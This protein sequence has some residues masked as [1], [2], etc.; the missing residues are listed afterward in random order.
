MKE[1]RFSRRAFLAGS[2]AA[3]AAAAFGLAGCTPLESKSPESDSNSGDERKQSGYSFETA[4]EPIPESDISETI[5]ADVVI[6]GAGWSGIC[7]A[8]SCAQQGLSVN[9]VEQRDSFGTRGGD[10]NA[11]WSKAMEEQGIEREEIDQVLRR[12]LQRYDYNINQ[13]LWMRWWNNSEE[14]MNWLIDIAAKHGL[15]PAIGAGNEDPVGINT[16]YPGA[17]SFVLEDFDITGPDF[18]V[19]MEQ[20]GMKLLNPYLVEETEAAGGVFHYNNTAV[21]LVRDGEGAGRVSAIV[22]KTAD[23]TY[24][25]FVGTK[26]V[27]LAT[28]DYSGDEDMMQKYCAWAK[29]IRDNNM[30]EPGWTGNGDGHKMGMWAGAAW[31]QG[32]PSGAQI[33]QWS[34]EFLGTSKQAYTCHEGLMVNNQGKRFMN[35]VANQCYVAMAQM[36]QPNYEIWPIWNESWADLKVNVPYKVAPLFKTQPELDA[37]YP[38]A[39][40][41]GGV[42]DG[43]IIKADT[44]EELIAAAGLP[45]E[46][47][48][49]TIEEYNASCTAGM[50]AQ[51]AKDP[52]YLHALTEGPF[53]TTAQPVGMPLFYS[54]MGG[55][56][57]NEYNNALDENDQPIEGLYVVGIMTG[58]LFNGQYNWAIPGHNMGQSLTLG[59]MLGK[60]LAGT[61]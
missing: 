53:Y 43:S 57:T 50:D 54:A 11:I 61:E 18:C 27:V 34:F 38:R 51:F 3:T 2:A 21:Q 47:T 15:K 25:K 1:T 44:L 14:S 58:G 55:L 28:G 60:H 4:P 19:F 46:Q 59:Y 30:A 17:H 40:W 49:A 8:L 37:S 39:L 32:D 6:V 56:R 24:K 52:Q 29:D 22:T 33:V 16:M 20:Y 42:E 48:M 41:A 12:D 13:P 36:H 9:V 45:A 35:E 31:Q 10:I 26:G 5:E 7:A 23:D